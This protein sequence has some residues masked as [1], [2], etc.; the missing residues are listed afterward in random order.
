M[1]KGWE[2]KKLEEVCEE[3]FAGGDKPKDSFSEIKTEKYSIPI[4]ANGEKNKG[5]YGFT[6][7][8]KVTKQ[9]ITVSARGTIGYTVIR[10]SPFYP[11]VRLI[12]I[13][14]NEEIVTINYLKYVLENIDFKNSGTSIPQLT[15]PLF[16]KY[17]AV[18]PPLPE[19]RTVVAL[20]DAAFAKIDK[21]KA[22]I[23]KN[24]ENARELFQ[25]KLNAV[26]SQRGEGWEERKL[27][28]VITL[29]SGTT[30]SKSL[31]RAEG[32]IPY[33][34]VSDMN[35]EGNEFEINTST[36]FVD[37]KA[38][39]DKS[40]FP[41][42]TIIFPKRGGAIA[43]NKKRITAV[44][45]C[46]DLNTMGAIPSSSLSPE[47]LH[48]YFRSFDLMDIANGT[49]IPQINNYSFKDLKISFPISEPEQLSIVEN[50]EFFR[51]NLEDAKR[52]YNEKISNLEDLKKSL[53]Q[54]AFAGEL[55]HS[56][57]PT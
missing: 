12:V 24:I 7:I 9:S 51:V 28:D 43:T 17:K 5:L 3:I 29:K 42:G 37:R 13:T 8:P 47:Y 2:M 27:I 50:L 32:E 40:I 31:E 16:K 14:P 19:Q 57:I 46:V 30:L 39:K 36:K 18:F 54:K 49:A 10:N 44:P 26:F 35:I 48:F 55:T 45:V 11:I 20:L 41:I 25:S 38:V 21:A 6:E 56:A 15:V 34:K 33:L 22:N 4:F 52:V 23:E 1:K 53:L